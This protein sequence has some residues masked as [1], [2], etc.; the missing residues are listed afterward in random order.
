MVAEVFFESHLPD[1]LRRAQ[2]YAGEDGF[3]ASLN[4]LRNP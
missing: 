4:L 3:V 1:A 2:E